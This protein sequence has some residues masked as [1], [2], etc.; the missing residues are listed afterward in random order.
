MLRLT[1][2]FVEITNQCLQRCIHC[3]SCAENRNFS[4]I[5][6]EDLSCLIRDAIP[7]GLKRFTISGGEPFLYPDLK[8]LIDLLCESGVSTVLYTCGIVK[9]HDGEIGPIPRGYFQ[10]L[11]KKNVEKV[12]F[13]LHGGTIETQAEIAQLANS[14]HYIIESLENAKQELLNV[15]LHVVPMRLNI[16]ELE[17]ILDL[18]KSKGINQVSFLRFVPQGRGTEG[19]LLSR[20]E[21][22]LLREKY[23]RW[24]VDYPDLSIRFGAPFNC[25]TLEGKD[26]SAGRSKLLISATGEYFPCEAFKYLKGERPS[27]Y[28]TKL[29]SV[30]KNDLLLSQLRHLK[31][32][33]ISICKDCTLRPACHGGCAGQRLKCNGDIM[34]GPDPH[35]LIYST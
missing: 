6:I 14:Y 8:Q 28:N 20:E 17:L 16:H 18:A 26:C 24:K 10:Y 2:L 4:F 31:M 15:E 27:I 23:K 3:S 35:C 19:L 21:Q 30:W 33:Q 32:G 9:K 5:C 7:M 13:S 34:K 22:C 12:I 29:E 11:K 25:L 1:E